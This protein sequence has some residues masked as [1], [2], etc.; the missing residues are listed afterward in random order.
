[1]ET[2]AHASDPVPVAVKGMGIVLDT[3]ERY[4]EEAVTH[5]SLGLLEGDRFFRM[6]LGG[7]PPTPRASPEQ[8]APLGA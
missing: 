4:D 2:G 6:A 7:S 1:M 8:R 3:V 5:G